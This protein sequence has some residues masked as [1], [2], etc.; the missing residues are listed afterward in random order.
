VCRTL[1]IFGDVRVDHGSVTITKFMSS[2]MCIVVLYILNCGRTF[3]EGSRPS[4]SL[5]YDF[6]CEDAKDPWL[7]S[8]Y[9]EGVSFSFTHISHLRFLSSSSSLY[10]SPCNLHLLLFPFSLLLFYLIIIFLGSIGYLLF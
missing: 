10:H 3:R 2:L 8:L 6:S 5:C 7:L 1:T 9:K 4:L